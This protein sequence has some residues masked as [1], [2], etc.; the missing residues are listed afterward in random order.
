MDVHVGS[1]PVQ[2]E[3]HVV[4][5]SPT[6]LVGPVTLEASDSDARNPL[7][8]VGAEVSLRDALNIVP[9]NTPSLDSAPMPPALG[10]PYSFLTSR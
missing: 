7:P 9:V 10:L 6:T 2:S 5:S 4:M 8:A 1:L 3:E